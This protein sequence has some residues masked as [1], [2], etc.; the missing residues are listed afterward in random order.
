M[1]RPKALIYG[2]DGFDPDVNLNLR[3]FYSELGFRVITSRTLIPA[4]ILIVTRI[5]KDYFDFTRFS[6][7]HI[8]DYVCSD[9]ENFMK[10]IQ[11]QRGITVFSPS[12]KRMSQ[13]LKI[14][15]SLEGK[16]FVLLPPVV[17]KIWMKKIKCSPLYDIAHIGNFKPYYNDR[18]DIFSTRFLDLLLREDVDVWGDGWNML[19]TSSKNH[20]RA[21]LYTARSIYG[22]SKVALGMMFPYQRN[23]TISGRFWM[24]PLNGAVVLSEPNDFIGIIPGVTEFDFQSTGLAIRRDFTFQE[25]LELSIKA[26]FYWDNHFDNSKILVSKRISEVTNHSYTLSLN[27]MAVGLKVRITDEAR[28]AKYRLRLDK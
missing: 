25:R 1:I 28:K 12:I 5:P 22:A 10:G 2:Y 11:S 7:I 3:H 16:I 18:S 21:P 8:Y 4:D 20:H 14:A 23:L 17:T 27:D 13:T 6:Q 24:G 19:L 9:N 26:K 15:P